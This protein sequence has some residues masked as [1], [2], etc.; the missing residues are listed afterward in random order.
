MKK[1][2]TGLMVLLFLC[3]YLNASNAADK[4]VPEPRFEVRTAFHVMGLSLRDNFDPAARI[5]AWV[6]LYRVQTAFPNMVPGVEYAITY[7]APD[8]D[9]ATQ[10]GIVFL[11]GNEVSAP[12]EPPVGITLRTVPAARYAVFEHHGPI[13]TIS[14]TYGYI[15]STWMPKHKV[16]PL[17]Q[18][19]F[20]R[21]D[22][23]FS[24]DSQDSII[25]IW[26]PVPPASSVSN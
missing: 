2:L 10:K 7:Y 4:S 13:E 23:R 25:E 9:P 14:D 22:A 11:V 5:R 6:D 17:G 20:E 16:Q 18:D 21:Y 15:F 19:I 24:F 12:D 1:Y 26:V 8:Y 3:G